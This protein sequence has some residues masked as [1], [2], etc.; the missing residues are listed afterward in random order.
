M[1]TVPA[2][3]A[4]LPAQSSNL[5]SRGDIS[6]SSNISNISNLW[7][8]SLEKSRKEGDPTERMCTLTGSYLRLTI[9]PAKSRNRQLSTAVSHRPLPASDPFSD[10]IYEQLSS[11][12]QH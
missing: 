4:N 11:I 6:S 7:T 12:V 2:Q 10:I 3:I 8:G 9:V 5:V 1:G